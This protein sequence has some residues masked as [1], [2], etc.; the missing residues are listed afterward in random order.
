MSTDTRDALDALEL[1]V[2]GL[3]E[4]ELAKE[5]AIELPDRPLMCGFRFFDGC[6]CDGF[7]GFDGFD[8]FDD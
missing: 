2:S 7:D 6:F 5:G 8:S 4:D 3:S 1:R